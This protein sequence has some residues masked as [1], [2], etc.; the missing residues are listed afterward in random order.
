MPEGAVIRLGKVENAGTQLPELSH[1]Q[2]TEFLRNYGKPRFR[3]DKWGHD[4]LPYSGQELDAKHPRLRTLRPVAAAPPGA[5]FFF[6]AYPNPEGDQRAA[7]SIEKCDN[8]FIKAAI[9]AFSEH[10]PLRLKPDHVMELLVSGFNVWLND[11]GGASKLQERG[12]VGE[13]QHIRADFLPGAWDAAVDRLGVQLAQ[14]I[15][16]PEL[17]AVLLACFSTTTPEMHRAHTLTVASAYKKFVDI[18]FNTACGIPSVT[19]EGT[20]E[21]WASLKLVCNTL[22]AASD[23]ELARWTETANAAL[24]VMIAAF[25]GKDTAE[26]WCNFVNHYENCVFSG[27]SGWINAFFPYVCDDER[28][29]RPNPAVWSEGASFALMNSPGGSRWG[30]DNAIEEEF[31]HYGWF[32]SSFVRDE[33]PWNDLGTERRVV[34]T[35]GLVDAIQW[36]A[37]AALEPFL[38]FQIDVFQ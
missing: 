17:R 25:D 33:Y 24:D 21:D 6:K 2:M 1:E 18:R 14:S 23:G 11:F 7:R 32:L 22:T 26:S 13:R 9:I 28:K 16:H 5:H 3:P 12:L 19:L 15:S 31:V 38:S 30:G 35:A 20:R 27:C 37:D 36:Q 8:A 4:T 29:L 10:L 34:V